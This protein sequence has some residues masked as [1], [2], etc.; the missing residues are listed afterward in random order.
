MN[1]DLKG[2]IIRHDHDEL[3]IL[4][5]RMKWTD[6]VI[7]NYDRH[8]DCYK[9][10]KVDNGSWGYYGM[11]NGTIRT[12]IWI[13]A[14]ESLH[15]IFRIFIAKLRLAWIRKPVILSICYDYF[16]GLG[17]GLGLDINEAMIEEKIDAII[18]DIKEMRISISFVYAARSP[19]WSQ[20]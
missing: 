11:K 14:K 10:K 19:S 12:F 13:P 16:I 17:L 5:E 1:T 4:L 2:L 7:V 6:Q 15:D 3:L 20:Y 9:N 18:E 8:S